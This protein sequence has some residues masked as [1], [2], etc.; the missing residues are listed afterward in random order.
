MNAERWV[1]L[2]AGAFVVASLA[3]GYFVSPWFYLFA[4][5]VGANLFQSA[6]T[7][8]CLLERIV[9][10]LGT[11]SRPQAPPGAH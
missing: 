5:F 2:F 1:R 10:R 9:L 11:K 3:L 4:L 7:N 6:L 8:F